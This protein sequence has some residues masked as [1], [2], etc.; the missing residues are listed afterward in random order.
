VVDS[1]SNG[2]ELA[3][4]VGTVSRPKMGKGWVALLVEVGGCLV[5]TTSS[6]VAVLLIDQQVVG[7][8]QQASRAGNW[9]LVL[10][11]VEAE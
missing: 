10:A 4:E 7:S 3:L 9:L 11:K 2:D 5:R 1:C 8:D 6:K